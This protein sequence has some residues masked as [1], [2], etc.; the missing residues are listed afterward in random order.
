MNPGLT[1]HIF[2]NAAESL[3]DIECQ[4]RGILSCRPRSKTTA[5]DRTVNGKVVQIKA[6]GTLSRCSRG[7]ECKTPRYVTSNRR[8]DRALTRYA[9]AGVDI[10]AVYIRPE[11]RWHIFPSRQFKGKR[12]EI[13]RDPI[14]PMLIAMNNWELLTG[15][16]MT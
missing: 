15:L 13:A 11:D 8:E 4:A 2:G 3:F 12:I 5:C 14:G 16:P 9:D 6:I 1:N 7:K 10:L